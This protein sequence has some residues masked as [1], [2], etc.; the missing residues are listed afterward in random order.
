MFKSQSKTQPTDRHSKN[1]ATLSIWVPVTLRA[2]FSSL[3][4][5]Q[6]LSTS[7]VLRGL[8]VAYLQAAKHG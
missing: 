4:Q 3:C 2:E 6:D 8:M 1:T 7:E 5:S